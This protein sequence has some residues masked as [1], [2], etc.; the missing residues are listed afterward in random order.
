MNGEPYLT[1]DRLEDLR[2]EAASER[3]NEVEVRKAA[4]ELREQIDAFLRGPVRIL[5]ANL[6]ERGALEQVF[7]VDTPDEPMNRI[8]Q[9]LDRIEDTVKDCLAGEARKTLEGTN[10]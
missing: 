3:C 7:Y 1:A 8:A 6:E 2:T 5:G 10:G 9:F 4:R